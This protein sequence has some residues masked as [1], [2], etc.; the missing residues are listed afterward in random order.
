MNFVKKRL[1][2]SNS[3]LIK[4]TRLTTTR[5][6]TSSTILTACAVIESV[7]VSRRL[8]LATALVS[9]AFSLLLDVALHLLC[10][11]TL[12]LGVLYEVKE[13]RL[14]CKPRLLCVV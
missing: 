3:L 9:V 4:C 10:R 7:A 6:H 8:D 12:H 1:S 11:V 5:S 13:P 2:G 14:L